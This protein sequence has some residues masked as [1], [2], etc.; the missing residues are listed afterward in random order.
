MLSHGKIKVDH[1]ID[2]DD[3]PHHSELLSDNKQSAMYEAQA[4]QVKRT[5][6]KSVQTNE[7]R[8]ATPV[9]LNLEKY[10][11]RE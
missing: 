4:K 9:S 10:M 7:Q 8:P 3:E 5:R 1:V 11:V 6:N 2:M